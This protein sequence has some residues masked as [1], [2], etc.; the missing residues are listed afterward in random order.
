MQGRCTLL[1]ALTI[2]K[3]QKGGRSQS[4]GDAAAFYTSK[5]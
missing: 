1:T 4:E 2:E 3:E 5:T